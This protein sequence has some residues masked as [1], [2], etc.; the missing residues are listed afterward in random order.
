MQV[1]ITR[2]LCDSRATCKNSFTVGLSSKFA[3]RIMT[4]FPLHLKCITTLPCEIQKINNSNSL[5]VFN[6]VKLNAQNNLLWH[7]HMPR[8]VCATHP[9]RHQ[10]HFVP[11][12]ARPSSDA[13]SVHQ[14]HELDECRKC[15]RAY[16][17]AEGGHF[18][19]KCD[20][21]LYKQLSLFG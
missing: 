20:S 19:I 12:R 17:H 3:T 6:S 4:Y 5:D 14:P 16:I 15:F 21:R 9:L 1:G 7:E 13:A 10:W 18:S 11:S 2:P 8:D